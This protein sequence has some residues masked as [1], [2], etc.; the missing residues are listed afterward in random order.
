[1]PGCICLRYRPS[2]KTPPVPVVAPSVAQ[3]VC[4]CQHASRMHERAAETVY[5]RGMC[6][7]RS[8][9]CPEYQPADAVHVDVPP[10]V[11]PGDDVAVQAVQPVERPK[12]EAMLPCPVDGCDREFGRVQALLMHRRRAHEGFDPHA[13]KVATESGTSTPPVAAASPTEPDQPEQG[14]ST[15]PRPADAPERTVV[16]DTVLMAPVLEDLAEALDK[17]APDDEQ[18]AYGLVDVP[19]DDLLLGLVQALERIES[20]SPADLLE[21]AVAIRDYFAEA[22]WTVVESGP[23]T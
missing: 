9:D 13:N 19:G 10:R 5:E 11:E 20:A 18:D 12:T 14:A 4:R 3:A 7:Q 23:V 21:Q 6:M 1:M 8:C 17:A 16:R 15:D 2:G 22:A